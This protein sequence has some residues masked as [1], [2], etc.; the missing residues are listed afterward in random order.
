MALRLLAA[1]V[2]ALLAPAAWGEGEQGAETEAMA[3]EVARATFTSEVIDREPQDEIASLGNDQQKIMYFTELKDMTGTTVTH[4]WE[5]H[6]KVMAEVAFEVG[7]PRWRTHSSKELDPLW[8]GEWKVS[9]VD[10]Q[11]KVLRTDTF[12]YEAAE[13][14]TAEM[15]EAEEVETATAPAGQPPAARQE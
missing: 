10:D 2:A 4:R 5:L 13:A 11:G 6:G 3:G 14:E 9:V 12:V 1:L 8:L 7:G 15:A